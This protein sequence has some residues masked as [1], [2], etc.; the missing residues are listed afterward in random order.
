MN[1]QVYYSHL[2]CNIY[3]IG[4]SIPT[5]YDYKAYQENRAKFLKNRADKE[6][7]KKQL[8]FN[9]CAFEINTTIHAFE[10][11]KI[12]PDRL[13]IE[14]KDDKKPSDAEYIFEI[15]GGGIVMR[16]NCANVFKQFRLG[17]STLTPLKIYE[18]E[19]GNLWS[20]ETFY[21]FNLCE[22]RHY[23]ASKQNSKALK[24]TSY[25]ISKFKEG[26]YANYGSV[27]DGDVE[28]VQSALDSDIDIWHDRR[29]SGSIFM[30]EPLY[31]ALVQADMHRPWNTSICKII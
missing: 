1:N 6:L 26:S 8:E 9:E 23:L 14:K 13:W 21:F 3:P 10:K 12:L 24:F 16:E 17:E 4:M 11:F 31:E 20:N 2:V 7:E 30:S 19:T 5:F 15:K 29:L 18:L 28:L 22:H 25:P 27:D